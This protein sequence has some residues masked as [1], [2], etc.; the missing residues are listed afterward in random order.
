MG[1]RVRRGRPLKFKTVEE[2][3][4]KID[5][6]FD[7]LIEE[8][9]VRTGKQDAEGMDIWKPVLDRH[10]KPVLELRE[11]PLITGLALFLDT[12]RETLMDY[13]EKDDFSDTVK[14]AKDK[15]EYFTEKDDIP[16][17]L[18]IFKL[19][20]MGWKDQSQVDLGGAETPLNH[21]IQVDSVDLEDRVKQ[22]VEENLKDAL[23]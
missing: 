1:S 2:L 14:R 6:Y 12:S 8:K 16:P 15:I 7:S 18:K 9:W 23:Q 13:E 5:A 11:P 4:Q 17:V 22:L 21:R 20:N 10:G 3:Q 19:K